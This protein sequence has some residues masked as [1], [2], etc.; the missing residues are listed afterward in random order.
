VIT[1]EQDDFI[2]SVIRAGGYHN[3][4][5]VISDALDALQQDRQQDAQKVE[6]LRKLIRDGAKA[7][8]QGDF[9]EI[10]DADLDRFLAALAGMLR[11]RGT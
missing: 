3:A 5:E 7:L 4:D 6:G 8:E 11:T 1:Q 10:D 2:E 9:T